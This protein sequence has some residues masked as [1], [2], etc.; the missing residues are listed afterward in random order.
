MTL[1]HGVRL[2]EVIAAVY[3]QGKKDGRHD[4][5]Q[6]FDG[7]KDQLVYRPPGQPKKKKK[8]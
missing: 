5:I 3:E 2:A 1:Y 7:I 6:K 8:K 4:V